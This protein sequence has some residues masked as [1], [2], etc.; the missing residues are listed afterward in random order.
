MACPAFINKT[1]KHRKVFLKAEDGVEKIVKKLT[2]LKDDEIIFH[3]PEDSVLGSS[4]DDFYTIKREAILAEK[5]IFIESVDPHIEELAERS[6]LPTI[7]P[8]FNKGE[9]FI[10]DIIPRGK[11]R[12][13][14]DLSKEEFLEHEEKVSLP[15]LSQAKEDETRD[16]F[17]I[18]KKKS[19]IESRQEQKVKEP[20][21]KKRQVLVVAGVVLVLV[22]SGFFAVKI[23]PE[24]NIEIVLKEIPFSFNENVKMSTAVYEAVVPENEEIFILPGETLV[25]VKNIEMKFPASG[26][27]NIEKKATGE[28][29]I[30]NEFSSS[31]QVLVAT[32][33]F[34]SPSGKIF[35]LD[36]R[37]TVPG[38]EIVEGK[39][40][41]SRIKV[42][43]TADKAGEEYNINPDPEKKWTIPAFEENSLTDRYRGFYA[44]PASV[45]ESGYSGVARIPTE[46]DIQK[47]EKEIKNSLQSALE[48][49]IIIVYSDDFKVIKGARQFEIT[50]ME[51]QEQADETGQFGIFAEAKMR[52][53]VFKEKILKDVL[54]QKNASSVDFD[55][56][57]IKSEFTYSDPQIDWEEGQMVFN[58]EGSFAL[59]P[60]I[61]ENNLRAQLIGQTESMIRPII[62]SIPGLKQAR[63][64]LQPFWVN[65][66]PEN[67]KKV[68]IEVK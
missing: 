22:V 47:A 20:V 4:L 16:F 67:P 43:V 52:A 51:V 46:E 19:K 57:I 65:N 62:F 44:Y 18:P 6:G 36:E 30:Y 21:N 15:E 56:H 5:K 49:Q 58:T 28:I 23:L 14:G 41:P 42:S 11:K 27:E 7:N 61:N 29:Y 10:S 24:A 59:R 68:N 45:M 3:V 1:M 9:R 2:K 8:I 34:S 54:A 60:T 64:S 32:T 25:A 38:A 33:R 50:K 31:P 40:F 13:A 26:V 48:N 55:Y 53:F 39:I 66:V 37:T 17:S 12:K 63:I 35:R